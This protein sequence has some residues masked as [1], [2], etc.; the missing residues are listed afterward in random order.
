MDCF[1]AGLS[2]GCH[3]TPRRRAATLRRLRPSDVRALSD[4]RISRKGGGN[5]VGARALP[6]TSRGPEP[7]A[8]ERVHECL[9]LEF[10]NA[11]TN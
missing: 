7:G 6:C 3:G 9:T 8:G 5:S 11:S 2:A 10:S 4:A 1:A